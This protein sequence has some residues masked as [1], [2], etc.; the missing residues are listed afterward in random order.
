MRSL[1]IKVWR[2]DVSTASS[3]GKPGMWRASVTS[4]ET[5]ERVYVRSL[6]AL[7]AAV[8]ASVQE[9]NGRVGWTG[10]LLLWVC[11]WVLRRQT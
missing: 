1:I 4:V 3:S 5:G 8:G 6:E 7:C 10:R 2:E 11:R 9:I